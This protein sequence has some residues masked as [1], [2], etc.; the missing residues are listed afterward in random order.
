MAVQ[1]DG[2][3]YGVNELVTYIAD[4]YS[5]DH[6]IAL[7]NQISI[8]RMANQSSQPELEEVMEVQQWVITKSGPSWVTAGIEY[9]FDD[10]KEPILKTF[11]WMNSLNRVILE[12][13]VDEFT[14]YYEKTVAKPFWWQ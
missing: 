8:D 7:N 14:H 13:K 11:Q 12:N 3:E 4:N 1:A 9:T 10:G 5:E 2:A 6:R